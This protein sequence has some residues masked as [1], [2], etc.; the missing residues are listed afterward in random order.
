MRRFF[1][2]ADARVGEFWEACSDGW[3]YDY[4]RLRNPASNHLFSLDP[5]H[6]QSPQ[7]R[8]Q[9]SLATAVVKTNRTKD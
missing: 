1:T 4:I 8:P 2:T 7:P 3:V 5:H 9:G 6:I